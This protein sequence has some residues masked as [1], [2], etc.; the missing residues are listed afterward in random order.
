M[1]VVQMK[2]TYGHKHLLADGHANYSEAGTDIV[3]A[4][5]S[6]LLQTFIYHCQLTEGK[7]NVKISKLEMGAGYI[8][9]IVYD[10]NNVLNEAFSLIKEGLTMLDEDYPEYV[11]LVGEK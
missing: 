9:L 7:K 3:C 2:S 4:S 11:M 6:I 8:H 10:P 5:V 1:T